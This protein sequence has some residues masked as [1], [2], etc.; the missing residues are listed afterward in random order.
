MLT[1]NSGSLAR[2]KA[3][4]YQSS[5]QADLILSDEGAECSHE[6]RC[7]RKLHPVTA[8]MSIMNIN[9]AVILHSPVAL[10]KFIL[11]IGIT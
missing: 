11:S 2:G 4:S 10:I 1:I 7:W 8:F 9:L 6:E 5:K 3:S